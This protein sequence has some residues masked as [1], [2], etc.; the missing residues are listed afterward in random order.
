MN[1]HGLQSPYLRNILK[2]NE[3]VYKYNTR[4]HDH[5]HMENIKRTS[6]TLRH[7]VNRLD[8]CNKI[9]AKLISKSA[10]VGIKNKIK[11]YLLNEL[12]EERQIFC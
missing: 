1:E 11:K 12:R 5:F 8:L 6:T 4:N 7:F 9:L 3:N 2:R 10:A